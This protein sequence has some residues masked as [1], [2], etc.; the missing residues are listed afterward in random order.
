MAWRIILLENCKF[1]FV[2]LNQLMKL[3]NFLKF[4]SKG[5]EL[6]LSLN[7]FKNL[8]SSKLIHAQIPILPLPCFVRLIMQSTFYFSLAVLHSISLQFRLS[9]SIFISSLKNTS[10]QLIFDHF[11]Y[12]LQKLRRFLWQSVNIGFKHA[13]LHKIMFLQY[14]SH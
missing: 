10:F 13:D 12:W 14:P 2:L 5:S 4:V 11:L 6:S 8:T 3:S 1:F 7:S 9:T